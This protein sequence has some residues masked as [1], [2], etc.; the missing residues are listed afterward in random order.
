LTAAKSLSRSAKDASSAALHSLKSKEAGIGR[1]D[2]LVVCRQL[3]ELGDQ[4]GRSVIEAKRFGVAKG[5]RFSKTALALRESV[6]ELEAAL[7]RGKPGPLAQA[8]RMASTVT[9]S[10]QK[11]RSSALSDARFVDGIKDEEISRRFAQAAEAA[12]AAAERLAEVLAA[13]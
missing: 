5:E 2:W 13:K 1:E 12:H 9:A 3:G 10:A 4:A 6:V 7:K 11:L 8:K